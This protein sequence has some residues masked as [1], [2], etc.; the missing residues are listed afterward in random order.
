MLLG[1]VCDKLRGLVAESYRRRAE[2]GPAM[3]DRSKQ[4]RKAAAAS[5]KHPLVT[6]LDYVIVLAGV[7]AV[8]SLAYVLFALLTEALIPGPYQPP[9]AV[10]RVR[11][12]LL[13]SVPVLVYCVWAAALLSMGRFYTR[14]DATYATFAV[15]LGMYLGLP[16]LVAANLLGPGTAGL[17][18]LAAALVHTFQTN[19][20]ALAAL[21]ALRFAVGRTVRM[22]TIT[23]GKTLH[24]GHIE[25]DSGRPSVMR[26]CWELSFCRASL[27]AMCPR[28]VSKST[29]WKQ[30][31][32]CYCDQGLATRLLS[33]VGAQ[34][35]GDDDTTH[36][37]HTRQAAATRRARESAAY[38]AAGG[39]LGRS[40]N[41][42]PCSLCPIYL[43]HQRYKYRALSWVALPMTVVMVGFLLP[44][45]RY[46]YDLVVRKAEA[47]L[48]HAAILPGDQ[49]AG[50]AASSS[51]TGEWAVL[52]CLSV[53]L[54]SFI[55]QLVEVAI[56]RLKL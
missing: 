17:S 15:G 55:L 23:G 50:I 54:L 36:H 26:K 39:S 20:L 31:S 43:D 52:I 45:F 49:L 9:E 44:Y 25:P 37:L 24:L 28:Y 27:R 14:E 46:F 13:F 21:A 19:G 4:A 48:P 40:R 53:L 56:F 10:A 47:L 5:R 12:N 1:P 7:G 34:A 2:K 11:D 42:A 38:L 6:L 29:C 16:Q 8:T 3:D 51:Y 18:G 30:N 32:G 22:A 41:R 33:A 35:R